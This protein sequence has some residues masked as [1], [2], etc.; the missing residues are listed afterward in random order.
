[1]F[2]YITNLETIQMLPC[3]P[4]GPGSLIHGSWDATIDGVRF[5]QWPLGYPHEQ[6]RRRGGGKGWQPFVL[7]D[8]STGQLSPA[9]NCYWSSHYAT[10][11]RDPS[12]V[13]PA[14]WVSTK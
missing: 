4:T 5:I 7:F 1:M 6:Q 11:S 10:V 14:P 12:N 8:A 13:T 3:W 9:T 2:S